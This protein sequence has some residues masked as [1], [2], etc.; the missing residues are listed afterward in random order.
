MNEGIFMREHR[1]DERIAHLHISYEP[2]DVLARDFGPI[3]VALPGSC[4]NMTAEQAEIAAGFFMGVAA[5]AKRHAENR[6]V[7]PPDCPECGCVMRSLWYQWAC[8][9]CDRRIRRK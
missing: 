9:N 7:C 8:P 5:I 3:R 4:V 2:D 6:L 1:F